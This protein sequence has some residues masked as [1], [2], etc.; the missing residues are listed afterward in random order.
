MTWDFPPVHVPHDAIPTGCLQRN[1]AILELNLAAPMGRLD[2]TDNPVILRDASGNAYHAFD[3]TPA[4][5]V[6]RLSL[7]LDASLLSPLRTV[8]YVNV[9]DGAVLCNAATGATLLVPRH[10]HLV[11]LLRLGIVFWAAL[12]ALSALGLAMGALFSLPTAIFTAAMLAVIHAIRPLVTTGAL[13]AFCD[14]ILIPASSI[15]TA[16]LLWGLLLPLLFALLGTLSLRSRHAI[17]RHRTH[18]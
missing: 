4:T 12:A 7:P 6:Q 10:S 17:A 1:D 11:N 16:L 3:T 8:E 5:S 15:H 18:V 13:A 14:Q 9:S 2:I